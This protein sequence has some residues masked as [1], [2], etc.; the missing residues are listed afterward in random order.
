MDQTGVAKQMAFKA[1]ISTEAVTEAAM[2]EVC[3]ALVAMKPDLLAVFASHHHE[4]GFEALI[5]GLQSR[6]SPRNLVGCTGDSIIGPNREVE[7]APAVA[8]WAARMPGVRVLPFVLDQHDLTGFDDAEDFVDRAGVRPE[9][10]PSFV[11]LP[12]PFSID[13]EQCLGRMNEAYPGCTIVGGMASG[14]DAP[15]QNRL[16]LNDQVLRQGLVG[17]S[18]SGP[19]SITPVVSQGCRPIGELLLVTK[20][21]ENVIQEIRGHPAIEIL[22][23][24]YES[25]PTAEKA[26]IHQGLFVGCVV[27]RADKAESR[28]EFLIRNLLGIVESKGLA[29]NTLVKKGQVIQ[30]HV[31]DARSA[32]REMKALLTGKIAAMDQAP[33]GGLLFSCN[34][35]GRRMFGIPDHDITLVNRH[36]RGCQV[37]GFFAGG[38]IGPLGGRAYIHGFTSSLILFNAPPAT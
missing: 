34:G 26:L 31:R 22:R 17:V 8:V 35:R 2:E 25:A 16:F 1:A 15:G 4:P 12:D 32:S 27:G 14:A 5:D 18:L 24:V 37:A 30:F 6:V 13:A 21:K 36:A 38:E 11:L 9:A 23:A 29:V 28:R 20:A 19:I 33:G 10:K 3:G 7:N